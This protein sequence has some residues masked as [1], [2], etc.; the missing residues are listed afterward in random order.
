[1]NHPNWNGAEANPT[2]ANFG[3]ITGKDGSRGDTS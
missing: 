3:R 2:N 1:M